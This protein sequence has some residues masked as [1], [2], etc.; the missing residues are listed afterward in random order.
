MT[1]QPQQPKKRYTPHK[2]LEEGWTYISIPDDDTI[3]AVRNA[4]TKVM[5]LLDPNGNPLKDQNGNN[6][7]S[8][9]STNIVKV[10]T[11]EEYEVEKKSRN[12]ES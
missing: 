5:K 10:L 8:F 7:Y 4:V 12:P 2:T 11:R 9:E 6:V 3:I 1:F